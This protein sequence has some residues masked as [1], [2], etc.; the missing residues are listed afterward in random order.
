M[1]YLY[2]KQEK[3]SIG[4]SNEGMYYNLEVKVVKNLKYTA[5]LKLLSQVLGDTID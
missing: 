1:M 5:T 4:L 2:W 3:E